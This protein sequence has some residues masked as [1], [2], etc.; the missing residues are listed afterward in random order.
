M[1][2]NILEIYSI[3]I[4]TVICKFVERDHIDNVVA[5]NL[6]NVDLASM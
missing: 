6:S 1:W 2:K 4:N 3:F 5:I